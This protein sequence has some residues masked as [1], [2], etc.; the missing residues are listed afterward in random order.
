MN[1]D[2]RRDGGREW[3]DEEGVLMVGVGVLEG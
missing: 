2:A 3:G 1:G